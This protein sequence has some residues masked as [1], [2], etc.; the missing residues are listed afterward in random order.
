MKFMLC[1]APT[2]GTFDGANI[3]IVKLAG[4]ENN[5]IFGLREEEVEKVKSLYDGVQIYESSDRVRMAVDALTDGTLEKDECFSKIKKLLLEN[6]RYMVLADFESFAE[7]AERAAHDW[8]NKKE[9]FKKSLMN[10]ASS[11]YFSSD[12][13]VREYAK[14]IWKI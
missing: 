3:E 2:I 11:A 4:E 10:T 14:E 7:T 9:Y 12:R 8:K 1:G 13:T 6:D 5:Y